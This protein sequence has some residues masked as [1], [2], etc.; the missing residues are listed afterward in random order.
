M[1]LLCLNAGSSTLKMTLFD[2]AA[3]RELASLVF[4]W[5]GGENGMRD[6]FER[7]LAALAANAPEAAATIHAVG[8]RVV[9]CGSHWCR[10]TRI[11]AHVRA[12]IACFEE[13]APL[14]NLS[15]LQAIT[16]AQH[17]FPDLPHVAV[18]DTTFFADLPERAVIYPLPYEWHSAWGVRRFGFHGLSHDYASAR[19]AE[20]LG[21]DAAGLRVVVLHL[22]NGCSASAVRG[23]KPV[24]TS[25]GFTP[26]DGLMMGTRSGSIDPGI[27][28]YVQR[29]HGVDV[30]ALDRALNF[31]S[32]LLGVSGVSGDV[33]EVEAEADEGNERARLALEIYAERARSVVGGL[34]VSMGGVDVLVFTA[35]VGEHSPGVRASICEGLECLGLRMDAERNAAGEPDADISADGSAGR[36]LVVRAREALMIA[37]ATRQEAMAELARV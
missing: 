34:A 20:I 28:V 14:H 12:T 16:A 3:E 19:A 18:F 29:R 27:L 4:P 24:A 23:G 7:G 22:G 15:E 2:D 32:G 11:D 17:R 21:R 33:R 25:M 26:L 35:G 9:H 1:S 10:P 30:E 6:A 13:F 36:V 8:H 31:E 5:A 37:R